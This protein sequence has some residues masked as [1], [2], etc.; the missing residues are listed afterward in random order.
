[1]WPIGVGYDISMCCLRF[2]ALGRGRIQ[3]VGEVI[4][5]YLVEMIVVS[6]LSLLALEWFLVVNVI[7]VM[8]ASS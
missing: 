6:A 4:S 5:I 8:P 7:E 1:M 2:L 3:G